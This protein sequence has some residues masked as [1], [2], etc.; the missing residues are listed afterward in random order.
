[1]QRA[2]KESWPALSMVL[3]QVFNTGQMLLT[4][5]VVDDGVSVCTLVTYRFF[6]GAILVVP[7]AIVL[8]KLALAQ[9]LPSLLNRIKFALVDKIYLARSQLLYAVF[10]LVFLDE[11]TKKQSVQLNPFMDIYWFQ[12]LWLM[13]VGHLIVFV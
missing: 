12:V 6:L 10:G 1:M 13:F 8:E 5:V 4:K 11:N 2:M 9:W 7:L 3:I